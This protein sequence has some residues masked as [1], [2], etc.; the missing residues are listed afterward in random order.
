MSSSKVQDAN[1][2][3]IVACNISHLLTLGTLYS[4]SVLYKAFLEDPSLSADRASAS[5]IGSLASTSMLTAGV[6]AGACVNTLG[7]RSVALLG[8]G[9][10]TVGLLGASISTSVAEL[11]LCFGVLGGVGSNFSFSSGITLVSRFFSRRRA[12]ATGLAVSGS[13]LGTFAISQCLTA[14]ILAL[15]WRSALQALA[16]V[17][18]VF[19]SVCALVYV[20]PDGGAE[21]GGGGGRPPPAAPLPL[22]TLVRHPAWAPFAILHMLYGGILWAVYGHFVTATSDWGL[23]AEQGA[24]ALSLVGLC[25]AVGRV[26]LGWLA[27]FPGVDKV[28]LLAACMS[29]A[30]L[31]VLLLGAM[32]GGGVGTGSI[33]FAAGV[34]GLFSGSVVAQVPPLLAEHLGSENLP[35][36]LGSQYSVQ[37]P[38]V[39]ALPPL[40]G[41]ARAQGGSYAAPFCVLGVVLMMAPLALLPLRWRGRAGRQLAELGEEGG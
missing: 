34:F 1:W 15:G 39:L 28:L 31:P 6:F 24:R 26:A 27:D 9:L 7:Q 2:G 36:A 40:L 23:T 4:Y 3:L 21:G 35:L 16:G 29:L 19:L 13:G 14:A 8:A 12:L 22:R 32:G 18:F 30:G 20:P 33:F 41:Y 17:T 11:A 25:G 37:V 38:T 10:L 5:S